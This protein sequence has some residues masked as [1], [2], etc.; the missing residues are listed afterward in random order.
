[1]VALN[2]F[3]RRA[4][5]ISERSNVEERTQVQALSLARDCVINKIELLT[6]ATIVYDAIRFTELGKEKLKSS[7]SNSTIAKEDNQDA[8]PHNDNDELK[9]ENGKKRGMITRTRITNQIF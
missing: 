8:N 7:S 2:S 6:N 5:E 1:M 3:Q 9:E 4:W